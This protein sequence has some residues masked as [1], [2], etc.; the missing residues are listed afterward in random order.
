MDC[1]SSYCKHIVITRIDGGNKACKSVKLQV[2][3][4]IREMSNENIVW[5]G[6]LLQRH[7]PHHEFTDYS[8]AREVEHLS[9]IGPT[10]HQ[11]AESPLRFPP[12]K[13]GTSGCWSQYPRDPIHVPLTTPK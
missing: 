11:I 4:K 7:G 5:S 13:A 10:R 2:K 12:P 1:R 9:A 6:K 3:V 8:T